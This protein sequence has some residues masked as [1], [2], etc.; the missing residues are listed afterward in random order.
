[1][2]GCVKAS[3]IYVNPSTKEGGGSITLLEAYACGLPA[4][5][6]RHP[7]GVD[8]ALVDEGETGWWARTPEPEAL[9]ETM[10]DA[11][12]DDERLSR[13]SRVVRNF[14]RRYDWDEVASQYESRYRGVT[15][16]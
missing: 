14:V 13:L 5:V 4:I 2:L 9:A 15:S 3:R 16:P 11:V 8:S 12:A 10:L 7:L 6:V 1:M